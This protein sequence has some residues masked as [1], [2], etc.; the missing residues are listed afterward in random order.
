[1]EKCQQVKMPPRLRIASAMAVYLGVEIGFVFAE[2][3]IDHTQLSDITD[4]IA[5]G[6]SAI[7]YKRSA[8]MNVLLPIDSPAV[9]NSVS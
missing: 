8:S 3:L 5:L 1:M 4:L 2:N 6:T 9:R 7:A